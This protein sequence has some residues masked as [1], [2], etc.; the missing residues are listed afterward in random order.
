LRWLG[1]R[2]LTG[3]QG[4][5]KALGAFGLAFELTWIL[6]NGLGFGEPPSKVFLQRGR[7]RF[8]IR[9]KIPQMHDQEGNAQQQRE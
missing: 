4:E 6:H 2:R 7:K 8:L 5:F 3:R 9:I 1:R